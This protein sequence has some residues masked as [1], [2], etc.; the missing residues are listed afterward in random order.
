MEAKSNAGTNIR[1]QAIA[2]RNENVSDSRD[3]AGHG[4]NKFVQAR[5]RCLL[6]IWMWSEENNVGQRVTFE[7]DIVIELNTE[8]EY[9][10]SS[11]IVVIV[12]GIATGEHLNDDRYAGRS[13]R[14][15][16]DRSSAVLIASVIEDG[17][18]AVMLAI[19]SRERWWSRRSWI[20]IDTVVCGERRPRQ[21]LAVV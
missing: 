20:D 7:N 13:R 5:Q 18:G 19:A 3:R 4:E 21:P 15:G 1:D 11:Q 14:V 17:R 9:H 16:G 12:K 6:K 2:T 8:K 10:R